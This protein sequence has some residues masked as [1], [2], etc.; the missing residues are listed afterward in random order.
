MTR[1]S[2]FS[3]TAEI[4]RGFF[5][6]ARASKEGLRHISVGPGKKNRAD[7]NA[8]K[9]PPEILRHLDSGLSSA[10]SGIEGKGKHPEVRLVFPQVSEFRMKVW[11][12][13][14]KIPYGKTATYSAVAA[15]VGGKNHRRAVAQALAANVFPILIP[16]HRVVGDK[17]LCGYSGGGGVEM[18]KMLLEMES[19]AAN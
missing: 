1:Q 14:S 11:K 16:C 4:K 12:E 7:S 8:R 6:T 13:I 18:K 19:G 15:K 5:I 9:I 3:K 10:L 17:G 2:I